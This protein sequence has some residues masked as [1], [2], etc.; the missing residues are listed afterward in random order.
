MTVCDKT[1]A[2]ASR[3]FAFAL[4]ALAVTACGGSPTQTY[5][6][7]ISAYLA[8]VS[9]NGVTATLIQGDAPISGNGP[10]VTTAANSSVITGGSSQVDIIASDDFQA[11]AIVVDGVDG[12]YR[13]TLPRAASFGEMVLTIGN[14][15]PNLQFGYALA[16]AGVGGEFGPYGSTSVSALQVAGGDIQVSVTWNTVADVDLHVIDPTGEEIYYANR[17]SASGGKLDL[18]ANAAC[19]TSNIFQENIGWSPNTAP[20]GTYT[21]RVEYWSGCQVLGTSFVVTI[22][23]RPG[24]PVTPIT[25]GSVLQT[26]S[27]TFAGPGTGGGAGAG[28]TIAT[29]TF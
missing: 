19:S 17:S 18:D 25:P 4:L 20:T 5:G 2:Q 3:I 26:F 29:F 28:R 22:S 27:G 7:E 24:V 15:L 10:S 6:A 23:T 1:P 11:V 14:R 9:V 13:V 12:Y 21:V 16:V 8:R